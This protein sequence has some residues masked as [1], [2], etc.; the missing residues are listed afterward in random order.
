MIES[1]AED[2]EKHLCGEEAHIA[3]MPRKFIPLEMHKQIVRK[4]RYQ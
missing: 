1:Y 4:V 2:L 3:G